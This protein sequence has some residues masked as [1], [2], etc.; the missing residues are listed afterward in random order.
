MEMHM[1]SNLALFGVLLLCVALLH[2]IGPLFIAIVCSG[3]N[4]PACVFS[5][6][7]SWIALSTGLEALAPLIQWISQIK[8]LA[9]MPFA[10]LL[11]RFRAARQMRSRSNPRVS[12]HFA[13][14]LSLGLASSGTYYFIANFYIPHLSSS[15]GTTVLSAASAVEY[16]Y[17]CFT[18]ISAAS[19]HA[20]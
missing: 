17:S 7:F 6:A 10:Y 9:S 19:I 1:L 16:S 18:G 20:V 12:D 3:H 8:W 2:T 14:S 15:S 13:Y 4:H 5:F 11:F